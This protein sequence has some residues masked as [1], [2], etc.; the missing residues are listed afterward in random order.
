MQCKQAGKHLLGG[1]Q[2]EP[3]PGGACLSKSDN[4]DYTCEPTQSFPVVVE[5]HH[6]I[7][8]ISGDIDNLGF[9]P[10]DLSWQHII[11]EMSF[12]KPWLTTRHVAGILDRVGC[13]WHCSLK[14]TLCFVLLVVFTTGENDNFRKKANCFLLLVVFKTGEND[15][16]K[17][18]AK[19]SYL[20]ILRHCS[21]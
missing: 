4:L 19:C 5:R 20:I 18:K 10:P 1:I 13:F 3:C 12:Q 7:A 11:R 17:K 2:S 8:R 15:D 14:A 21:R 9:L 6:S 16:F